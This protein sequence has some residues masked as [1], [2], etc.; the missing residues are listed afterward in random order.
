M[1]NRI[2]HVLANIA[3]TSSGFDVDAQA[4]I[5]ATGITDETQKNA[6]NTLVLSLKSASLWGKML[7]IYPL[8]G[9][10]ANTTKYNLKDS[11]D[12]DSAY[13]LTFGTG[14]SF[15]SQGIQGNGFNTGYADTHLIPLSSLSQNSAHLSFY[16]ETDSTASVYDMGSTSNWY[17]I[18]ATKFDTRAIYAANSDQTFV[19]QSDSLGYYISSRTGVNTGEL[20]KNG[21]SISTNT[22]VSRTPEA[23]SMY[24][25]SANRNNTAFR[26][27]SRLCSFATI[28]DGL[29]TTE[30]QSL[31]SIVQTYRAT[32]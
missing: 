6:I 27:S 17:S 24:L 1:A 30:A 32:K 11:R 5:Y 10:T 14:V 12:L 26:S 19:A 7:A 9:G 25:L 22:I 18:I 31:N 4:F 16:S 29:T 21:V 3:N 15:T 23:Y 2:L 13:R 20:V 8:V 28:G